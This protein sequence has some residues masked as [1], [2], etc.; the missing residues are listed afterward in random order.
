[1]K[2]LFLILA[3]AFSINTYAQDD[4]TVTLVVSGQGKTQDEARQNALRSAIEQAY[5]AFISS[6][7]EILNDDLVKD[8]IVAVANGNIK[9]YDVVSTNYTPSSDYSITIN[10]TVSI[11]KLTDFVEKRGFVIELQGGLFAENIKLQ[12]LY[13]ANE[14]IA[15]DQICTAA[16]KMFLQSFDY[17]LNVSQPVASKNNTELFE[18]KMSVDVNINKNYSTSAEYVSKSLQALNCSKETIRDYQQ[19]KKELLHITFVDFKG[20]S[21][22]ITLRNVQGKM[23]LIDLFNHIRS[24]T[25]NFEIESNVEKVNSNKKLA[26]LNQLFHNKDDRN[27]WF[28]YAGKINPGKIAYQR[29]YFINL[30]YPRLGKLNVYYSRY[31]GI[32]ALT[33]Y[34][35]ET[36]FFPLCFEGT[37]VQT[38]RADY[39]VLSL[40]NPFGK[41]V[42]THAIIH[43][44]NL[45][46]IEKTTEYKVVLFD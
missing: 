36:K 19:L 2:Q 16:K 41:Y 1:M 42:T 46:V 28:L 22:N 35:D 14:L 20:T 44:A 29:A 8:E 18:M 4:K 24:C 13:E 26:N 40:Y 37:E 34:T 43:T 31:S 5:G 3:L 21:L 33:N 15:L 23:K 38:A 32:Y 30:G 27:S 25:Y 10:A 11:S 6:K 17:D 9:K 12:K 39:L 7:T 45:K